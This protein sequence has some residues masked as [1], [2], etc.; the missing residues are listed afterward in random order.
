[1]SSA[2]SKL[3]YKYFAKPELVEL[4]DSLGRGNANLTHSRTGMSVFMSPANFLITKKKLHFNLLNFTASG[5]QQAIKTFF[6]NL[7][8]DGVANNFLV[9]KSHQSLDPSAPAHLHASLSFYP[10]V[11]W[12]NYQI[13]Y[14]YSLRNDVSKLVKDGAY[15]FARRKDTG[16]FAAANWI[17]GR[18]STFGL[19]A[20]LLKREE[21]NQDFD[22]TETL[23]ERKSENIQNVGTS[24]YHQMGF[25][26]VAG[27][28]ESQVFSFVARNPLA[29]KWVMTREKGAPLEI[30]SSYDLAYS[31]SLGK[32]RRSRWNF[33]FMLRDLSNASS[34]SMKRRAQF[35]MELSLK[36]LSLRAGIMDLAPTAGFSIKGGKRVSFDVA[37]YQVKLPDSNSVSSDRRVVVSLTVR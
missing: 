26:F 19:M 9:S 12:K 17:F 23:E 7:G 25:R 27:R 24:I 10:H 2:F 36:G 16:P 33:E 37:T 5:N 30:K 15:Q 29:F 35:G 3:D 13:G 6:S 14:L 20:G 22:G 11:V 18:K 4:S 28:N 34:S 1:M 31:F 32:L 21:I 8:K